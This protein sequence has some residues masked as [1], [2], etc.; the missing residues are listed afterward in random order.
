M[1]NRTCTKCGI[2]KPLNKENYHPRKDRGEAKFRTICKTCCNEARRAKYVKKP[3]PPKQTK[4]EKLAYAKAYREKNKEEIARKAKAYREKNKEEI[5]RK[6][7]NYYRENREEI[8]AKQ[9]SEDYKARRKIR[10]KN[11]RQRATDYQRNRRQNNPEYNLRC[12]V[13]SCIANTMARWSYSK[14]HPTWQA[15]PYTP[16]QLREHLEAQFDE[17]MTWENYGDY[18]H[19]DHIYPQSLLP[20]DSLEHENFIKC[21]SLDNLQPLEAIE[22]MRKSNKIIEADE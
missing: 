7:K 12:R 19:I 13:S 3:K 2:E 20:Y 6:T 22:N 18:W 11:Y 14:D 9:A 5:A 21:W 4:E 1:S 10:R 17:H 8:L 16:E 15:L